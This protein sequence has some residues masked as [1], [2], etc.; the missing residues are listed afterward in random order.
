MSSRKISSFINFAQ[1]DRSKIQSFLQTAHSVSQ[2]KLSFDGF[3]KTGAFLFFEPSTRTR[4]SFQI[5]AHRLGIATTLLEGKAGTSLEKGETVEDTIY[6][7]AAMK[8]DFMVIRAGQDLALEEIAQSLNLPVLNAGW[9]HR[10]HPTQALL[11]VMTIEKDFTSIEN[12]KVLIVGDVKHSRV[13]SSHLQLAQ[14]LGYEV[15]ICGPEEFIEGVS[16]HHFANLE[17]GLRWAD[18]VMALRVQSERHSEKFAL[19]SYRAQFSLTEEKLK[20]LKKDGL[21]LHPGPINFGVELE[22]T[23]LKDPRNRIFEQVSNGV[24]IRQSLIYHFLTSECP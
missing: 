4:M 18:V 7:V 5:A 8:P 12:K 2:N 20:I 13:A 6:N 3:G 10:A 11:D 19:E 1:F 22:R 16:A 21:V 9:G 24:H 14:I 17:D 15:A 23:V